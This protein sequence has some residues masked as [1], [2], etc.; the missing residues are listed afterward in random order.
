LESEFGS[1]IQTNLK[2]KRAQLGEIWDEWPD[3]KF[4][5]EGK[6]QSP[7]FVWLEYCQVLGEL[8]NMRDEQLNI[9]VIGWSMNSKDE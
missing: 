3:G 6:S 7:E 8:D 2:V 5:L 9:W 4:L 1:L